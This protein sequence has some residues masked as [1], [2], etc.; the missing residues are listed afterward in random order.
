MQSIP[1]G[2]WEGTIFRT[3]ARGEQVYNPHK[4]PVYRV[5]PSHRGRQP[6]HLPRGNSSIFFLHNCPLAMLWATPNV[7]VPLPC[8]LCS[9]PLMRLRF[10]WQNSFS[11]RNK[12]QYAHHPWGRKDWD[13]IFFQKVRV[14]KKSFQPREWRHNC[15]SQLSPQTGWKQYPEGKPHQRGWGPEVTSE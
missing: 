8:C 11:P 4:S 12:C 1:R 14:S 7:Q 3:K 9:P 5:T 10:H 6:F 15:G 2:P 13:L